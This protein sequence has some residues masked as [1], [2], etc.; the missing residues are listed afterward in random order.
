MMRREGLPRPAAA[1]AARGSARRTARSAANRAEQ[2]RKASAREKLGR[3]RDRLI[4]AKTLARYRKHVSS[5]FA[6][7]EANGY[8]VPRLTEDFDMLVSKWAEALWSEG[9]QKSI[10]GNG[11]SGLQHF[12]PS[13][14]HRLHGSWRLHGAWRRS[15]PPTQVPPLT[16][17]M[18]WGISGWFASKAFAD[19]AVAILLAFHCILRT[20]EMLSLLCGDCTVGAGVVL[21]SLRDT[22]IGGRLGVVQRTEVTDAF[23]FRALVKLLGRKQRGQKV[24]SMLPSKFRYWWRKCLKALGIPACYTPYGLRRGGATALFLRSGSYDVVTQRGRWQSL[25]AMRQYV[26][27]ALVHLASDAELAV[28][29]P[30]CRRYSKSLHSLAS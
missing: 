11:L 30:L 17:M 22:K 24:I 4:T 12:I 28:W 18:V 21:L 25:H 14:R 16:R 20:D 23:L 2:L 15:E 8:E 6:W 29:E 19:E 7:V 1:R 26:D 9:D 13:L 3:L 10:L 27:G 5:F